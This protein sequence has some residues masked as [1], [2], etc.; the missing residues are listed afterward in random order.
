MSF[1]VND[2]TAPPPARRTISIAFLSG[3][4][5]PRPPRHAR[6][7]GSATTTCVAPARDLFRTN[8]NRRMTVF[9]RK[10]DRTAPT[11]HCLLKD[12]G[13][14]DINRQHL[15]LASYAVEFNQIVEEMGEKEPTNQDWRRIDALFS[16]VMRYVETHF[17]D[18]E[19][20]MREHEYPGFE[21]HKR[22]HD[23]FV[24]DLVKVQSR[25][26][27][28][29]ARFRHRFGSMLWDWL[30]HHINEEDYKYREFFRGKGIS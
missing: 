11:A 3:V 5:K 20:L 18:E 29:E 1:Q 26:N 8:D 13:V 12:V 7:T 9:T 6:A 25:I 17:R 27:N 21:V 24:E 19:Q 16:R 28:R 14:N 2:G 10:T 15:R 23:R 22:I 4:S 30:I